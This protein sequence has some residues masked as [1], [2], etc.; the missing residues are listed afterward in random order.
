MI[1]ES[2]FPEDTRVKNEA[3]TLVE[4]GYQ[5]TVIALNFDQRKFKEI[6][7]GVLVY[8]LPMITI[9]KK[10]SLKSSWLDHLLYRLKSAIGYILEY[11]YFT[12]AAFLLSQY[13]LL[14]KGIDV[15]HVHN[16]PNTLFL[17]GATF[18][19]I[20]KKFVFDHHDLAP[21]LYLSRFKANKDILYRLLM[22]EEKL[23]LKLAH[24]VIATNQSYKEIDAE[25][26]PVDTGKIII[27]RNG[28]DAKRFKPVAPDPELRAS[29]RSILVYV[30]IMGPQDGVDYMLA[31]LH[32]LVH[33]MGRSDHLLHH[34][35]TWRRAW[36][37]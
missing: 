32:H 22:V 30:G 15:V 21:E 36:R 5:V 3:Y 24:M 16:P 2:P 12:L 7:N 9:F 18:R 23:C 37:I 25:R 26:G 19:L 6:V 28:P 33:E 31:A 27:V 13:L 20:R 29:G 34:Y 17:I 10:S 11:M 4:A 35:R 14:T 1:T 8:R